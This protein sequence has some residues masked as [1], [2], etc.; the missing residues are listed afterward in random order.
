MSEMLLQ[1]D[2]LSACLPYVKRIPVVTL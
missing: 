1:K 2:T